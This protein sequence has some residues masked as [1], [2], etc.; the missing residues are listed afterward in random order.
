MRVSIAL[1]VWTSHYACE[2]HTMRVVWTSHYTC[3]H[4]TIRVNITLYVWTSHYTCEHHT[5]RANITLCVITLYVWPSHY[6]CEHH[7]VRVN[8]T[9]YVWTSHCTCE[10]H[11]TRV[12]W[13]FVAIKLLTFLFFYS[14]LGRGSIY[15]HYPKHLPLMDSHLNS[16]YITIG[17]KISSANI[18]S[19]HSA[20]ELFSNPPLSAKLSFVNIFNE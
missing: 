8:I 6:T 1:C 18:S 7:T 10:H 13:K 20:L 2:H 19:K 17:R 16:A 3:E 4:H 9:L 12:F 11:T 15:L 14:F 5:I